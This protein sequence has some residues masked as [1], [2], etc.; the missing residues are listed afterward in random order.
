MTKKDFY[1]KFKAYDFVKEKMRYSDEF[2]FL[3]QFFLEL[4]LQKWTNLQT[5][6]GLFDEDK[7][8]IYGGDILFCE[9]IIYGYN[10][11]EVVFK[12]GCFSCK[13]MTLKDFAKWNYIKI[14][15]NISENKE[16]LSIFIPKTRKL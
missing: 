3:H 10:H 13:N 2:G 5:F 15:G 1:L 7:K 4:Y 9:N 16:L 6:T 8:E 12:N 14:A 11:F